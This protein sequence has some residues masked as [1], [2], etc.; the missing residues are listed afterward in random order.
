[1]YSWGVQQ[2]SALETEIVAVERISEYSNSPPEANWVTDKRSPAKEWPQSG[3]IE[4]KD[5][6]MRYRHGLPLVIKDLSCIVRPGEKVLMTLLFIFVTQLIVSFPQ[7]IGIVGRTGAGKSSLTLALF[8]LVEPA[9]GKIYIDDVDISTI[10]LHDI[11]KKLTVIPQEPLLF[12]GS[13]RSNIDPFGCHSDAEIYQA[14][15]SSHLKEFVD[16]LPEGLSFQV[17]ESG[18]NLSVGQRQLVC[19][20][21]AILK[22][23]KI[24]IMDEAT[25]AVDLETD[26]YVQETIKE[27]FKDSTVLTIAHRINTVV[28]CDRIMVFENGQLVEF[29]SPTFL[30]ANEDSFF[31]KMVYETTSKIP[32]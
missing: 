31:A 7:K 13:L 22:K 20:S 5:F 8:R 1:M 12:S 19:L 28:D 3:K 2:T 17:A 4:F 24:L 32:S 21:R 10:G 29:D 16:T 30:M 25:A 27:Q 23:S 15:E 18:S 9:F 26:S 11:R 6:S 14:L